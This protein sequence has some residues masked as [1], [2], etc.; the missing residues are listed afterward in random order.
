[1][2][3]AGY[4]APAVTGVMCLHRQGSLSDRLLVR[5]YRACGECH[6]P[7]GCGAL[8]TIL[9]WWITHGVLGRLRLGH[10]LRFHHCHLCRRCCS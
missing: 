2:A 5:F 6:Q 7:I 1:M 10:S 3:G 8:G 9:L 4:C